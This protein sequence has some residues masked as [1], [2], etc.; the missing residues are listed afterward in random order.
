MK[1][2]LL[3]EENKT[4]LEKIPEDVREQL[5]FVTIHTVEDLIRET[6]GIDLPKPETLRLGTVPENLA[7]NPVFT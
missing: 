1:K 5:T 4:D 6:I 2:I 7:V 3:P